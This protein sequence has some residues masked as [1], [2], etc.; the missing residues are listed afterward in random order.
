MVSGVH[1]LVDGCR[2]AQYRA[3]LTCIPF[4]KNKVSPRTL[5]YILDCY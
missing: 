1:G 4:V 2:Y 5:G 3:K